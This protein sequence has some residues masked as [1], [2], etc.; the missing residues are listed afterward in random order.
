MHRMNGNKWKWAIGGSNCVKKTQLEERAH[1]QLICCCQA[2]QQSG[3]TG[4]GLRGGPMS[5]GARSSCSQ[6]EAR[7][8]QLSVAASGQT[9]GRMSAEWAE[10]E[11]EGQ[12]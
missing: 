7:S 1:D 8:P 10:S 9:D 4:I 12:I 3:P 2:A 5:G 11:R 6:T